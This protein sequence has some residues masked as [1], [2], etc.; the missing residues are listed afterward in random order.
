MSMTMDGNI[1]R[2]TVKSKRALVIEI[3]HGKITN[4]AANQPYALML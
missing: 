2:R 3:I 1:K 4:F